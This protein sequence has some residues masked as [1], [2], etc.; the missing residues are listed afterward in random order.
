MHSLTE[1]RHQK[2]ITKY[3]RLGVAGN[4]IVIVFRVGIKSSRHLKRVLVVWDLL[5]IQPMDEDIY[6]NSIDIIQSDGLF[7]G[8][9]PWAV[10]GF[11]E[12]FRMVCEEGFVQVVALF[13][14][15]DLEDNES[16]IRSRTA[17]GQIKGLQWM[18]V[19]YKLT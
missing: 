18:W 8:F 10:Q 7:F 4:G 17:S 9:F 2:P 16:I 11:V 15:A 6:S 12:V 19:G 14:W 13:L 5:S 3:Q 1:S